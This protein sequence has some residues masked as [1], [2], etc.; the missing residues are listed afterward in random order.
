MK[1]IYTQR[2]HLPL[3][4]RKMVTGKNFSLFKFS[5]SNMQCQLRSTTKFYYGM[6]KSKYK[7][8]TTEVNLYK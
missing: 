5:Q 1:K 4:P 2:C 8:H 3:S 6:K 7:L